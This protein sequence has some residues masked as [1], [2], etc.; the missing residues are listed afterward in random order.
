[1]KAEERLQKSREVF[2]CRKLILVNELNRNE[3][4]VGEPVGFRRVF[5]TGQA[6]PFIERIE[7][8]DFYFSKRSQLDF[9][10]S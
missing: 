7:S 6:S 8:I 2:S 4:E 10:R 1:L 5:S 3:D 9:V